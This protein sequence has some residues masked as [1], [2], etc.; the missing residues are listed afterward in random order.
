VELSPATP[1]DGADRGRT[2]G[3]IN[4][5]IAWL[6]SGNRFQLTLEAAIPVNNRTGQTIGVRGS[7][8]IFLNRMFPTSRLFRPR[9]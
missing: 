4:P 7:L 6:A 3:K 2:F 9:F 8:N 1:L 5:G